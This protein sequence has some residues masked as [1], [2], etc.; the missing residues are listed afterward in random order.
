MHASDVKGTRTELPVIADCAGCGKC[1][2]H[3][4]TPPMYALYFPPP[5]RELLEWAKGTED[6]Q[7]F[8]SLP[9]E[10]REEL[11]TYYAG[12]RAGTIVDRTK[13]GKTPCL[14]LNTE[15]KRCKNYEHRPS[16]CREF[17]VGDSGC[18]IARGEL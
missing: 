7:R 11:A 10:V 15:T 3:M 18:R 14:W 4:G 6:H 5:G 8:E 12:V 17:E 1:C 2:D 16:V 9:A 13:D